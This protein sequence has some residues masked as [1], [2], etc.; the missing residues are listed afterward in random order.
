MANSIQIEFRPSAM[1]RVINTSKSAILTSLLLTNKS[2]IVLFNFFL[3]IIVHRG[4]SYPSS[5]LLTKF[6]THLVQT[7]KKRNEHLKT[8][9]F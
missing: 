1:L 3:V 4:I 6:W 2:K 8:Q 7:L 5:N 9:W